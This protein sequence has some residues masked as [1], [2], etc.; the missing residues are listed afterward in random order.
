[1]QM[2][3]CA[4]VLAVVMATSA[5]GCREGLSPYVPETEEPD[6]S[7]VRRLTFSAGNDTD[8][9][10]ITADSVVYAAESFPGIP[11]GRGLL[12]A[13][14]IRG[15]TARLVLADVQGPSALG[16]RWL[17][18]PARSPTGD[19]FAF[20]EVASIATPAPVVGAEPCPVREPLLD[21]LVLRVRSASSAGPLSPADPVL[22]IRLEGRDPRQ[23]AGLAGPWDTGLH[24]FQATFLEEHDLPLH[25]SWSHDGLRVVFSDGLGLHVWNGNNTVQP[26]ALP[27]TADAVSPGW[28]PDGEWIAFTRLE[29]GDVTRVACAISVGNTTQ[30]QNRTGWAITGRR[31]ELVRPDGSALRTLGEGQ[32][33]AWSPDSRTLFVRRAGAI[34]AVPV[35]GGVPRLVPGTEG[36]RQPAAAPDGRHL[37]FARPGADPDTRDIWVVRLAR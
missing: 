1:M 4:L 26:V 35:D 31:L 29:R 9:V 2:P 7:A 3:R 8:P 16:P 15:G 37:A 21:S 22:P 12:V 19:R 5:P 24:P 11:T 6:T 25:P 10:F 23:K 13:T 27:G 18:Q 28:S 30:T 36:G 14:S 20:I 32:D 17:A 33:P 34:W